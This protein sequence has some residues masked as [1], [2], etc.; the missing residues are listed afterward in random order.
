MAI[1]L[2]QE[3]EWETEEP[4]HSNNSLLRA[5]AEGGSSKWRNFG[6]RLLGWPRVEIDNLCGEAGISDSDRV[7][8]IIDH[9]LQQQEHHETTIGHLLSVCDKVNIKGRVDIQLEKRS[10]VPRREEGTAAIDIR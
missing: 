5:V 9:W 8:A 7:R 2:D 6:S 3:N 10:C 4:L 1:F